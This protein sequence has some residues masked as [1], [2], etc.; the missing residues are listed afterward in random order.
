ME[1]SAVGSRVWRWNRDSGYTRGEAW[2]EWNEIKLM[3]WK[4]LMANR[5]DFFGSSVR[6]NI[7]S[8]SNRRR[9]R[10]CDE[11][12]DNFWKENV[13]L[14]FR[15]ADSPSSH[16]DVSKFSVLSYFSHSRWY[17]NFKLALV[18]HSTGRLALSP[19]VHINFKSEAPSQTVFALAPSEPVVGLIN[20]RRLIYQHWRSWRKSAKCGFFIWCI[21]KE[22]NRDRRV[23]AWHIK[24]KIIIF[25]SPTRCKFY[26]WLSLPLLWHG[27]EKGENIVIFFCSSFNCRFNELEMKCFHFMAQ[28]FQIYY[29]EKNRTWLLKTMMAFHRN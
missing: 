2:S 16:V 6:L 9:C 20:L 11:R 14:T 5:Y 27:C 23:T 21:K 4:V 15:R 8:G 26:S 3:S 24:W 17:L 18:C 7:R 13:Y 12:F 10:R 29:Y 22:K 1:K 28:S 19:N 25:T